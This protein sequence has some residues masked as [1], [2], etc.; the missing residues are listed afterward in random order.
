[1]QVAEDDWS[2]S[3]VEQR[4]G[5]QRHGPT[6]VVRR[7]GGLMGA[8]PRQGAATAQRR[9]GGTEGS[10]RERVSLNSPSGEEINHRGDSVP[11]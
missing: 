5:G 2:S 1:M 7:R 4:C 8:R 10:Y 9:R 11:G 6:T 3:V